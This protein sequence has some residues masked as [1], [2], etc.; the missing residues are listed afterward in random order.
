MPISPTPKAPQIRREIVVSDLAVL[1]E[2]EASN[3]DLDGCLAG[4][5]H[6]CDLRS[7]TFADLAAT[8]EREDEL[9]DSLRAGR[10]PT[11]L[12]ERFIQQ[13]GTAFEPV[14]DLWGLDIGVA[15]AVI[16]LSALGA[17]PVS[18]CNGAIYGTPHQSQYPYVAFYLADADLTVL[19][20]LAEAEGLGLVANDGLAHLYG[21]VPA[22]RRFAQRALTALSPA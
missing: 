1:S 7:M 10:D 15:G 9:V 16:A 18:S 3:A 4:N 22:L 12:E 14:D 6:Y 5:Q 21:S 17:T 11:A 20:A 19:L 2:E 13:R 8:L